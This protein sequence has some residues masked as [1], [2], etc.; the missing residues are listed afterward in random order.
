M[1]CWLDG[2]LARLVLHYMNFELWPR[3]GYRF[4]R[5]CMQGN[6]APQCV[7]HLITNCYFSFFKK[8]MSTIR[9][10]ILACMQRTQRRAHCSLYNTCWMIRYVLWSIPPFHH[11]T[12]PFHYSIPPNVDTLVWVSPVQ[13]LDTT[14][15]EFPFQFSISVSISIS[16]SCF[17]IRPLD[18]ALFQAS[19]A[20]A[21]LCN[22][23]ITGKLSARLS[24]KKGTKY[25]YWTSLFLR[26]MYKVEGC[27]EVVYQ[28]GNYIR[29]LHCCSDNIGWTRQGCVGLK[30]SQVAYNVIRKG[31]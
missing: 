22:M 16:I 5:Y 31:L 2:W 12:I 7:S 3:P 4:T 1:H 20:Y 17:S 18:F 28:D 23:R 29:L 21:G 15:Q 10:C 9:R 11:S 19:P 27:Y 30:S 25:M 6:P 24:T 14:V 13:W 8:C 26:Y